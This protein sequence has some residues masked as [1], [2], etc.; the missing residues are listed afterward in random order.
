MRRT[1]PWGRRTTL[2]LSA[3]FAVAVLALSAHA[4]EK[5]LNKLQRLDV[6]EGEKATQIVVRG[7][8]APTFTVFKLNDPVRL[9]IDVS[10]ADITGI[11]GPFEVEN[12]VVSQVSTLQFNDDL[13]RIG[14]LTGR[15]QPKAP[16]CRPAGRE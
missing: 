11:E 1:T 15:S 16:Q 9:F 12:G 3:L 7:S 6:E 5:T 8:S 13:V 2:S 4:D 10:N 14:R